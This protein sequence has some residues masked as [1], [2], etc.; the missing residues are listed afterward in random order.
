MNPHVEVK[1]HAI[2]EATVVYVVCFGPESLDVAPAAGF[3]PD[4]ATRI[5]RGSGLAALVIDLPASYLCGDE[6]TKRLEDLAWV[7]RRALR[8]E[9]LMRIAMEQGPI[10]P[11]TFGTV[12]ASDASLLR[13]LDEASHAVRQ[14]IESMA[15]KSELALRVAFNREKAIETLVGLELKAVAAK[16]GPGA[17]YLRSKRMREEMGRAITEHVA[18]HAD[19]AIAAIESACVSSAWRKASADRGDGLETYACRALLVSDEHAAQVTSVIDAQHRLLSPLG[20]QIEVSG[21]WP[22]YS[23]MPSLDNAA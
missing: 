23:F 17:A 11:M 12:F 7:T 13:R 21:P 3:E 4:Q 14:H 6:A 10:L 5:I 2:A 19:A 20:I 1:P 16:L 15:G 22:I 8:H 18:K 9:E